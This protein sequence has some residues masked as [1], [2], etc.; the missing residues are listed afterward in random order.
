[1]WKAILHAK[2]LNMRYFNF[3]GISNGDPLYKS[4]EGLTSFKKKFGGKEARHSDFFD[5]VINPF[6][7]SLYNLRKRIVNILS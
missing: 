6:W 5:L 3:G 7:Y 4:W 2:K 1:L